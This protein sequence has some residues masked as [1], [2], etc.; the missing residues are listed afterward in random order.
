M[1]CEKAAIKVSL[2]TAFVLKKVISDENTRKKV[3]R[4]RHE[5]ESTVWICRSAAVEGI[6]AANPFGE[7][8]NVQIKL[9][10]EL[11]SLDFSLIGMDCPVGMEE[12][13]TFR[14][15]LKA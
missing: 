5:S 3:L 13:L 14:K 12:M 6:L 15:L 9:G 2:R 10:Y 8:W 7:H 4:L 11:K 1:G